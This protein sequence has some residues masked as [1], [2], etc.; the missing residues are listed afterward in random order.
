MNNIS[1]QW[2]VETSILVLENLK[3][4]IKVNQ[5]LVLKF[6]L[7]LMKQDFLYYYIANVCIEKWVNLK[8]D[9]VFIEKWVNMKK[10]WIINKH[11]WN[12]QNKLHK[13]KTDEN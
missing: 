7:K 3:L 10:D 2:Q 11:D 12:N 4:D 1:I 9:N 13:E 6:T 8:K 5:R